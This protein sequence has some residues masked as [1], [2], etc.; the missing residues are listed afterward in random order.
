M[1]GANIR[2]GASSSE[3][4]QQ[5]K[6]VTN[7]LKLVSSE[8]GVATEKANLFGNAQDKL[9]AVHTELTAKIQAQNQ[10]I[11]LYQ[12]RIAGINGEI[13]KQKNKQTELTTKIE[14]AN[15]RYKESV[16]VTGK[17]SE[18]SKKLKQDIQD[19]KEEYAKNEKAIDANTSKLINA[20]TKMNSTE[21]AL[22]KNKKALEDTSKEISNLKID[23]LSKGLDTVSEKSGK[24]ADT[25]GKASLAIGA[26]GVAA[27]KMALDTENDLNTLQGKL[28]ITEEEA[29]K[30]KEVAKGVYNNGFGESLGDSVEGLVLLQQNLKSTK[31]W[32]DETKQATLEQ[33]M[34]VNKLFGTQTDE[35]TKTLAV[36]QNS[37]LTDDINASLDVITVGFQKGANYSGEFLDTLRE[38]SP[39]FVKLGLT[40][41]EALNFLITGAQNGAFNLDKVGDAMKEFTIRA[42]DDSEKTKEGFTSI[43]LNVDE[44]KK[45]FSQGGEGA[46]EAFMQVLKG[47][48]SMNDP[49]A[50]N[51][52]SV[53]LFGTMWEDLG[54]QVIT[55]LSTVSGG[56]EG[57]EDATARAGE[58]IN[59]S[60]STQMTI[61]VREMKD[62]LLP[63]GSEVLNLAKVAMP[64][65]KEVISQVTGFLKGL[66]DEQR[67]HVLTGGGVVFAAA[68]SFKGL[69]MLTG[70]ISS[71]IKS[72]K[73][74]RDFGGKAVEVIKDF[75]PKALDG[76]KAAGSFALNIGKSTLEFGKNA[77]QSGISLAQ[78]AAHKAATIAGTIAT[79]AMAGA[80]TALNFVL[81]MNPIGL[82]VIA[83]G[84]LVGAFVIAYNKSEWF[85]NGVNGAFTKVKETGE[86]V[87][88]GLKDF[89]GKWGL[90]ILTVFVPFIGVPL[91]IIKHWD[92]IKGF[93]S[94]LKDFVAGKIKDMFNFELPNIKLPHFKLD[95]EFSLMP[96]SVPSVGI[97][98][99]ANG[100][101][102]TKPG[103]FGINPS[104]GKFMAGGESSTGGEAIMPLK[105]L[106]ELMAEAIKLAGGNSNSPIYLQMEGSTLARVTN[107][108]YDRVNG[109]NIKLT[110]RGYGL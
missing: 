33:I 88:G 79:N 59:N 70:G 103:I 63:L 54:P 66:N 108:Y 40:A 107:K 26:A 89:L 43:G 51:Q 78:L 44:M 20:T 36:M 67:Q 9:K 19:L 11:K 69:S 77:V 25:L 62:S 21:K 55:S 57:V 93:F 39:Q 28:G 35:L 27:G 80:Q 106:P 53:N 31:N 91:Q 42:I 60:F 37:G 72:Y 50:Q 109:E 105:K 58:Q 2:I 46:K 76:A 32:S 64:Q 104:T 102:M 16:E 85:R 38:Y 65:L 7:Q 73:E 15:K 47:I 87:F 10:M 81:S 83:I 29:E 82:V 12:D 98:W 14:D 96:P 52:A 41:D 13:D 61:A 90:D 71:T 74:M 97:E 23:N 94:G 95:G 30:L 100:G 68:A 99:Y 75:S 6:E 34:T 49:L 110:A 24:V 48:D 92:E 56:I 45:K 86:W 84:L 18:E 3:F 17:S 5:M 8:C 22:L 4:Q 101:I 1:A